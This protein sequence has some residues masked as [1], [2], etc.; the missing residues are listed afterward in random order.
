MGWEKKKD[1]NLGV[2]IGFFKGRI[3]FTMDYYN[4]RTED[5]LENLSI[6]IS[7]GRSSV[8][9]NG[10]TVENRYRVLPQYQ[11]DQPDRPDIQHIGK[12]GQK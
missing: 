12:R 3:N 10:G 1:R 4:N 8:K 2:D 9:A 5:I 7:T 11:M 6:P